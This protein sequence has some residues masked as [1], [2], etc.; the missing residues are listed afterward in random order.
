MAFNFGGPQPAFGAPAAG[1][2]GFGPPQPFGFGAQKAPGEKKEK[3][4]QVIVLNTSQEF[5]TFTNYVTCTKKDPF[6]IQFQTNW[7]PANL[8][9]AAVVMVG[10]STKNADG[11]ILADYV[12]K[13]GV[14]IVHTY[15]C[16]MNYANNSCGGRFMSE[17][18]P[19]T[20]GNQMS[21]N[22]QN[23]AVKVDKDGEEYFATVMD[24]VGANNICAQSSYSYR[25]MNAV[26]KKDSVGVLN[27]AD[28]ST[29][30]A[31]RIVNEGMVIS[32]NYNFCTSYAPQQPR[33]LWTL[34][35]NIIACAVEFRNCPTMGLEESAALFEEFEQ[36][37]NFVECVSIVSKINKRFDRVKNKL[38][39]VSA[40]LAELQSERDV[41]EEEY[42]KGASMLKDMTQRIKTLRE[43]H[44]CNCDNWSSEEVSQWL[45]SLQPS[46]SSY[47][48]AFKENEVSGDLLIDLSDGELRTLGVTKLRDRRKIL[49]AIQSLVDG[50][51]GSK[52]T[53]TPNVQED[54]V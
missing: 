26:V 22:H 48:D 30:V 35:K 14:V 9:N 52:T 41:L 43:V 40:K 28:G 44:E 19:I 12:D 6:R 2:F 47:A 46:W 24:D 17:Y 42:Q 38:E 10:G 31:Y 20:F 11:D 45:T 27:F 34:I 54:K 1:G 51:E 3:F 18:H 39:V 50:K 16:T 21:F 53:P 5:A 13:G 37:K 29:F 15:C 49:A 36:Q 32:I 4:D 25:G 8:E 33:G 7:Q 23:Q